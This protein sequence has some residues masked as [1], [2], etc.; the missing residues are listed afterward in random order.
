VKTFQ[1]L[2]LFNFNISEHVKVKFMLTLFKLNL[3]VGLAASWTITI[4]FLLG[5]KNRI[6][7]NQNLYI[8]CKKVA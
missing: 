6:K 7:F 1:Q 3:Y 5:D 4:F 2:N 8:H